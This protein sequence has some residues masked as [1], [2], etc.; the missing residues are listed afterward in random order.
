MRKIGIQCA[1]LKEPNIYFGSKEIKPIK[2]FLATIL[3]LLCAV[4]ILSSCTIPDYNSPSSSD[5]LQQSNQNI[6]YGDL[7]LPDNLFSVLTVYNN[8]VLYLSLNENNEAGIC[9]FDMHSGASIEICRL[10]D[11]LMN[12]A[13]NTV[14]DGIL[15]LNYMTKDAARKMI[16]IDMIHDTEKTILTEDKVQGMVYSAA[17]SG[18]V[19]SL[20]HTNEW[21][22][23]IDCYSPENGTTTEF[24]CAVADQVILAIS[25]YDECVYALMHDETKGYHIV[26]YDVYGNAIDSWDTAYVSSILTDSQFGRFQ[27]MNET[28]F[29]ENF[30]G[31]SAVFR[32]DG[33]ILSDLQEW[34][35][36]SDTSG[37][38]SQYVFFRRGSDHN[39]ICYDTSGNELLDIPFEIKE[40]YVIRYV[41]MDCN[42]PDRLLISTQ[43]ISTGEESVAIASGAK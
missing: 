43:N 1:R 16:A 38:Y 8:S 17:V 2:K 42:N 21:K 13:N 41:F 33:T 40:G 31:E 35:I 27:V 24:L 11:Y 10:D 3:M 32:F 26:K 12:P 28:F 9:R 18:K 36:A 23:V 25:V 14:L 37:A 20:K 4:S 29:L 19:F 34:S 7:T 15:Y 39:I 5:A 30:S 22:S 6:F